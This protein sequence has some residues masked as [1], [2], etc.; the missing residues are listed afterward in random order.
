MLYFTSFCLYKS[1]LKVILLELGDLEV[2]LITPYTLQLYYNKLKNEYNYSSNTILHHYVLINNIFERGIKWQL[3]TS[4]SNSFIDRPKIQKKEPKIY[5]YDD[6]GILLKALETEPIKYRAS[7]ILCVDSSMRREELNTLLWN[8][9]NFEANEININKVRIAVGSEIIV[10]TPK[11]A[12]SKR[13]IIVSDVSIKLLKEL[14]EYQENM[15]SLLGNKWFNNENYVFVNDNGL[16][17]YPATLSKILKK[18]QIKY[19]LETLPFHGLRHTSISLLLDSNE[20][21]TSVSVRAG[22]AN[23]S[24]TLNMYSHIVEKSRKETADTMN[25]ILTSV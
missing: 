16:P 15:A 9:I 23:V 19:N 1:L 18:L 4:N 3:I 5:D 11:T 24:T 2:E 7:I 22:H 10:T 6:L 21:L 8:D 13:K 20:D 12:K 17:Y 25:N 14:K